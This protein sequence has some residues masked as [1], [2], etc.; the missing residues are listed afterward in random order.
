VCSYLLDSVYS[1]LWSAVMFVVCG[2]GIC[3]VVCMQ[4]S[5]ILQY[6][7]MYWPRFFFTV[8]DHLLILFH[9]IR[10]LHLIK[11]H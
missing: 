2:M 9:A 3:R 5:R 8:R 6:N 1:A 11:Q 10:L 7:I 4:C